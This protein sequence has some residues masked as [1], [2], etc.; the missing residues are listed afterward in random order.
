MRV[1]ASRSRT[2]AK[3]VKYN[4]KGAVVAGDGGTEDAESGTRSNTRTRV[5]G[6][7]ERTRVGMRVRMR[8]HAAQ[9]DRG[10]EARS[11]KHEVGTGTQPMRTR[12]PKHEAETRH[13]AK[14]RSSNDTKAKARSES[15]GEVARSSKMP[16]ERGLPRTQRD[17][18]DFVTKT[19]D[20]VTRR[21]EGG[22]AQRTGFRVEVAKSNEAEASSAIERRTL[23]ID[24]FFV[25]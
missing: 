23:G 9:R 20:G 5:R 19:E 2:R 18:R 13:A 17:L 8:A 25:K 15:R 16:Y 4:I 22:E 24:C 1:G 21:A 3:R 6:R 7:R 12:S 10:C 11:T 14:A